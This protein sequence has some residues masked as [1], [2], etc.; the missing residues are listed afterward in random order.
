MTSTTA[1]DPVSVP[2]LRRGQNRFDGGCSSLLAYSFCRAM[3]LWGKGHHRFPPI[4][5]ENLGRLIRITPE[6]KVQ[7]EKDLGGKILL[8][9]GHTDDSISLR[10][11]DAVFCGDAAMNGFPSMHRITIWIEDVEAYRQSW[12][13]MMSEGI[14]VLL[15]GHGAPFRIGDLERNLTYVA[16]TRLRGL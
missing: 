15:P 13:L 10:V 7:I 1:P 16:D 8:T 2:V 11:G 9:P 4:E 12:K 5:D 3:S 14:E 6:T